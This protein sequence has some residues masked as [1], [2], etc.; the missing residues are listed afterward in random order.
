MSL[1]L[2]QALFPLLAIMTTEDTSII[3]VYGNKYLSPRWIFSSVSEHWSPRSWK[4]SWSATILWG[5]WGDVWW[6]SVKGGRGL[7]EVSLSEAVPDHWLPL[8]PV[9]ITGRNTCLKSVLLVIT[10]WDVFWPLVFLQ[11]IKT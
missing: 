6:L 1:V 4:F 2:I 5:R 10:Q 11:G 7:G 3:P 9:S 8:K